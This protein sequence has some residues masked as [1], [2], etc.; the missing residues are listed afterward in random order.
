MHG[1]TCYVSQEG[2]VPPTFLTCVTLTFLKMTSQLFCHLS[3]QMCLSGVPSWSVSL[4]AKL[5]MW[6]C[7]LLVARPGLL[8]SVSPVTHDIYFGHM[9]KVTSASLSHHKLTL[10]PSVIN[11][12]FVGRYF[13]QY[14]TLHQP[15]K[16]FTKFSLCRLLVSY[17]IPWVRKKITNI[18]INL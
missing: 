7:A 2:P 15:F 14:P 8:T 5:L 16:L 10:S 11:E 9:I 6:C 13:V 18:G 4:A 17:F 12:N 1:F 3:P